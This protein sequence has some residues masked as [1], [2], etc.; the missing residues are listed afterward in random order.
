MLD[1]Y[2]NFLCLFGDVSLICDDNI[3]EQKRELRNPV[4]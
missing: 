1:V 3:K 2:F 4:L